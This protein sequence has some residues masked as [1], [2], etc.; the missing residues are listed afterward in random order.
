MFS[1]EVS[2]L[3]KLVHL[4][5]SWCPSTLLSYFCSVDIEQYWHW[6]KSN[7][8]ESQK[9]GRPR[10]TKV[11]VHRVC[12]QWKEGASKRPN[13]GVHCDSAVRVKP[14]AI[15]EIAQALPE[16]YHTSQPD[17]RNGE[18]LWY[19]GDIWIACPRKPGH[20]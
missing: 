18:N 8:K 1:L 20:C 7:T 17:E 9:A 2:M 14:I 4:Q 6:Q 11:L 12:K 5:S 13:E 15:D 10:Y 19:P 3:L 16:R